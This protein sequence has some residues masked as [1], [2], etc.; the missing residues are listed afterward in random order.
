M[1]LLVIYNINRGKRTRLYCVWP[2]SYLVCI[3]ITCIINNIWQQDAAYL[4]LL[5]TVTTR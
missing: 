2:L 3:L 4:I 5:C 1:L